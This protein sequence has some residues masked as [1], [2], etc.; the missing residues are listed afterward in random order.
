M[1]ASA[2]HAGDWP[3]VRGDGRVPE[4]E[5]AVEATPGSSA[6][7]TVAWAMAH[8]SERGPLFRC[9]SSDVLVP[10]YNPSIDSKVLTLAPRSDCGIHSFNTRFNVTVSALL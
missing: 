3:P 7:E 9:P 6:E 2:P 8:L 10:A 4:R 5:A 1:H